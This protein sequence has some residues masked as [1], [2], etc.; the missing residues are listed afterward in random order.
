M[1]EIEERRR[2]MAEKDGNNGFVIKKPGEPPQKLS[3]EKIAEMIEAQQK[4]IHEN[5]NYI[6]FLSQKLNYITN[7]LNSKTNEL[8]NTKHELNNT[9]NKLSEL[10]EKYNNLEKTIGSWKIKLP[11]G[12]KS[13]TGEEIANI[14]KQLQE[15]NNKLKDK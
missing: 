8:N 4:T 7:E 3:S 15:T 13:L 1:I 5:K 11:D 10:T 6:N 14:M 9:T 12:K 2:Q